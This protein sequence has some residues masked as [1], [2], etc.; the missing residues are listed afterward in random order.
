MRSHYRLG[1][2]RQLVLILIAIAAVGLACPT[3]QAQRDP[4]PRRYKFAIEPGT[5]M[6]DLLPTP[7]RTPSKLPSYL[8]E[9]LALVAELTFGEPVA[10]NADSE[11][12]TAHII[13]KINHLNHKDPDGFLKALA[14]DRA[15]LGGLPLLMGK[16]CGMEVDQARLFTETV[17]VV[18]RLLQN[19]AMQDPEA[20]SVPNEQLTIEIVRR[21]FAKAMAE[22]SDGKSLRSKASQADLD[23]ANVAAMMQMFAPKPA[24]FRAGLVRY[25]ATVGHVDATHALAR[26]ALFPP[27][28]AV[29]QAAIE[30]L[31]GRPTRDYAKTLLQGLR[32]P[33]PSVSTRAADALVKLQCKDVL[34]DLVN[35]LEQPDPRA[36]VKQKI[37]GKEV[38]TVRELVR[39]NHNRNCLL[40]HAPANTDGMPQ[41]VLTAAVPLP[42]R[43]QSSRP[44]YGPNLSPDIFVRTDV[45]Y[46]RQDFA[47]MMRVE[48][49]DPWPE[50]QRFDFLVRTRVLSAAEAAECDEQIA[51]QG[52]PSSHVA[53][54]HALRELSGRT[55]AEST[56]RAWRLMLKLPPQK[57]MSEPEA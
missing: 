22:K 5:P 27:E 18:Q 15:D 43:A 48:K 25:L 57:K 24:F 21:E 9:D 4:P 23:R 12:A 30:G 14:A 39:V 17:A 26:L 29:H 11:R 37:A 3:S 34:S 6:Q 54:Q 16:D 53:A 10:K 20:A 44:Y 28:P 49:A 32:Y 52:T 41:D 2:V 40:C 31:K 56:A 38:A 7:P 1:L 8:N 33:L 50:M 19:I 47:M 42:D 51:K 46:L 55:P 45:T 13:A 36:P 35:V